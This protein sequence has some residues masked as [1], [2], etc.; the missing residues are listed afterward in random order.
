MR[1]EAPWLVLAAMLASFAAGA[2]IPTERQEQLK[3][4][5]QQDCG[6][7]HGLRLTGGLGPPLTPASL[8]HKPSPALAAA[9]RHG[10]PGT[11]MPPWSRFVS[12]EE[13]RWLVDLMKR[14]VDTTSANE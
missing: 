8:A 13:A 10:R 6:S 1:A 9:I 7:C 5:L 14:G 3:H 11:P 2:D 12:A 4:L